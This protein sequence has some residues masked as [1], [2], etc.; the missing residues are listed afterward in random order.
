[1]NTNLPINKNVIFTFK[2][3]FNKTNQFE[4]ENKSKNY[5]ILKDLEPNTS[6]PNI[7]T[8]NKRFTE[9]QNMSNNRNIISYESSKNESIKSRN[10][11]LKIELNSNYFS[12]DNLQRIIQEMNNKD[13]NSY[14][15]ANKD[16]I[17]LSIFDY[18]F[19]RKNAKKKKQIKLYNKG[20]YFYRK[21]MDIVHVFT[22]LS[23]VED[24]I[25]IK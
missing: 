6:F 9:M 3:P 4:C 12:R 5:L 7:T 17:N 22:L 16:N 1:M 11:K 25:K 24:F 20:N 8:H 13:N 21:K 23:I 18:L 19:S 2:S 14:A 15:N 10:D